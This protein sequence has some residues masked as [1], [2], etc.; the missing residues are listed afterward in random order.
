MKPYLYHTVQTVTYHTYIHTGSATLLYL[1]R[2]SLS[3]FLLLH[4][5]GERV[6]PPYYSLLLFFSLPLPPTL[7]PSL[8]LLYSFLLGE[9]ETGQPAE[10]SRR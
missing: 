9:I 5:P 1:S 6:T 3:S 4:P 2:L 10:I 8:L 7:L